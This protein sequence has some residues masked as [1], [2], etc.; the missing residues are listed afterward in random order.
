MIGR[1]E[2]IDKVIFPA[3]ITLYL[4]GVTGILGFGLFCIY[5]AILFFSKCTCG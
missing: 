5:K 4:A 3:I 2:W 1:E